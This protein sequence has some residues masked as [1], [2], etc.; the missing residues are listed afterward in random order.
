MAVYETIVKPWLSCN[1]GPSA[2]ITSFHQRFQ[3]LRPVSSLASLSPHLVPCL[4]SPA[5]PDFH[6]YARSEP[7]QD[8]HK[9]IQSKPP[10][11]RISDAREVGCRNPGAA[12]RGA[13]A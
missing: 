11:V 3:A 12:V 13:H 5:H 2:T 10:E 7:V 9:P 6:L 4:F 8:R 1:W